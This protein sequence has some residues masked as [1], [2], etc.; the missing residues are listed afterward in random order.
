MGR[1]VSWVENIVM[2]KSFNRFARSIG[3]AYV[4]NVQESQREMFLWNNSDILNIICL[5][6]KSRVAGRS[7]NLFGCFRVLNSLQ[8]FDRIVPGP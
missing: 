4:R 6:L 3:C 5:R 1:V 7:S 8:L 2:F